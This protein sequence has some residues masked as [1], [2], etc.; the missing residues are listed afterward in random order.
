MK[1]SVSKILFEIFLV[2]ATLT[3][4]ASAIT[5]L[6]PGSFLDHIWEV[7]LSAYDQL[8]PMRI[9]A[10]LGFAALTIFLATVTAGWH[11][12]AKWGW[13]LSVLL[14]AANL[15]GDLGSFVIHRYWPD[16]IGMLIGAAVLY[17]LLRPSTRKHFG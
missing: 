1:F 12:Q 8:R 16:V 5:L 3:T 2:L 17:W 10:G 15:C 4:A 11:R 14:L 13:R 7:K 9:E 6:A